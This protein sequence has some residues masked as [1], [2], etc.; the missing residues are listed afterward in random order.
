MA[1]TRATIGIQTY[2]YPPDQLLALAC[3]ADRLGFEGIWI[4]EH[5]VNPA[6]YAS[7]HPGVHD[8][9]E[10][11]ED[12]V[13]GPGVTLYDPWFTL[14]TIAGATTRL[15]IGTAIT[16]VPLMH[17]LLLA[18]ATATAH[19]VS[20]GRF[21]LGTGAG[22]L[23]EEF[24]ALGIPFHERGSRLDEAIDILRKA[25]AGGY[26]SHSGKHFDFPE[27][28]QISERPTPVPLVCGGNTGPALRRVVRVADA[29]MNS[30]MVSLDEA[31]AL[32]DTIEAERRA[33]GK[34]EALAY[35]LRPEAPDPALVGRF[36]AAGFENLV[37]WGPH[38]WP[39]AG[40]S[41]IAQKEADLA[42]LAET[43]GLRPARPAAVA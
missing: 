25:W 11:K 7:A 38:I 39:K 13:L 27:A 20:G 4:G 6:S 14:G 31:Q 40:P 24:D 26:F 35:F 10:V 16:I 12:D 29:W 21:R 43:L 1:R 33:A 32:R 9:A 30:A 41:S 18:R 8:N 34:T 23:K 5:Y 2:N 19:I 15:N 28:Q 42:R 22:W 17:P 36:E 3:A 37:L